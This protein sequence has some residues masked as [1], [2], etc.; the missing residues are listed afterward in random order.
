MP[1]KR[2][3]GSIEWVG[4]PADPKPSDHW[5]C[6]VTINK[7]RVWWTI[8]GILRTQRAKASKAALD[9]AA[10]AR[11]GRLT[12]PSKRGAKA[13]EPEG[14][15]TLTAWSG[16]WFTSRTARGLKS[17]RADKG[18]WKTWVTPRL[19]DRPVA[20]ITRA[21]VEGWVEWIDA[22]VQAKRL[23]WKTAQNTWGL[24]SR[25][26][27]EASH[28]KVKALRCRTDNP[29]RDVEPPE[30]GAKKSKPYLYPD[31]LLQLVGCDGVALEAR[32]AY[33][34]TVYLYPRAGEVEALYWE[35][36]DLEHGSVLIHRAVDPDSGAIRE[37]K[38]KATRRFE[39]ERELLPLLQAMRAERPDAVM[40]FDPWPLHR[41]RA[42]QLR[43]MLKTAGVKRAELFAGDATR[44]Q[45]TFHDLR[46]TGTT[47]AAIR[48][49]EPLK[50]MHRAGHKDLAT[51]MGYV[52]EAENLRAGFGTVFPPLP[53]ALL[54][55]PRMSQGLSQGSG[56]RGQRPVM[57]R[58]SRFGV[59]DSNPAEG[60][61][62]P[63]RERE[64]PS[65]PPA[66]PSPVGGSEGLPGGRGTIPGTLLEE[67]LRA[68]LAAA[69]ASGDYA[70][71]EGL[72]ALLRSAA[73]PPAEVVD[74]AARRARGA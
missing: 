59:R 10:A 22:Q 17:A 57:R 53:S 36:L 33:A 35:D 56:P 7:E 39:I 61:R 69:V 37:T 12:A 71:A 74:L 65:D 68:S 13:T 1:A 21:D 45:L 11:A 70:A 34:V 51:T 52:R 58:E 30:G 18:R 48:G 54:E 4:D 31:E 49:D 38:G 5:R 29:C 8:P 60:A 32:R 66:A 55:A 43:A 44:K 27:V 9:L 28:G 3:T 20:A 62:H 73:R 64:T 47:W 67:S 25:A 23:S 15:E 50:I 19:G 26:F 40:V 24:V 14:G 46:A 63:P 42:R 16:R 41:F 2:T 72:I 6:R